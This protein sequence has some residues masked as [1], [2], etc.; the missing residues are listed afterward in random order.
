MRRVVLGLAGAVVAVG[1]ALGALVARTPPG[2]IETEL[3]EALRN[4]S[5]LT[6][7]A[8]EPVRFSLFPTPHV[9]L[10]DVTVSDASG[11]PVMT[12]RAVIA[13]PRIKSL[14]AGAVEIDE[15]TLKTPVLPVDGLDLEGLAAKVVARAANGG[16]LPSLRIVEGA[17]TWSTGRVDAIEAGVVWPRVGRALSLTGV[18]AY[19]GKEVEVRG[20][21]DDPAAAV[22]G[23]RSDLKVKLVGG[24]ARLAFEG[25]AVEAGDGQRRFD[26]TIGFRAGSLKE[27]SRWFGGATPALGAP[28]A[29]VTLS[30]QATIDRTGVSVESAELAVDGAN[31]IGATR[32]ALKDGRPDVEATLAARDLDLTHYLDGFSP[33]LADSGGWSAE[34][35]DVRPFR[36]LDLDLRLSARNVTV[37]PM[38]FGPTAATV[39]V[40][41]GAL[42]VSIGE[43]TAYGGVL[44]GRV[45]VEPDGR[46]AKVR[47]QVQGTDIDVAGALKDVTGAAP[48][49]GALS[50][51][52]TLEG[53]G[54][55]MVEIVRA[56]EGRG[57]A[58]LAGGTIGGFQAKA[59]A[60]L[61]A[62]TRLEIRSADG[63]MTMTRGVAHT[64]DLV[65]G[66]P[67]ATLRLAG[68]ADVASGK[69]SLAGTLAALSGDS[70][71]ARV[72]VDGPFL[73]PKL[74]LGGRR[75]PEHR[76]D[77]AP[78]GPEKASATP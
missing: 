42:D 73:A 50:A 26:G 13:T 16:R 47:L 70:L 46:T 12:A 21:I 55:T 65:L 57:A 40:A 77:V 23:R 25:A 51:D 64:D 63:T 76:S 2:A 31:F 14:L 28:L 27:L 17:V 44:G 6:V 34:S 30:G 56:L 33:A 29:D 15:V 4:G 66:G 36:A 68:E 69:M 3:L 7:A 5:G 54:A 78:T 10:D 53:S 1:V 20:R 32:F 39:S 49:S 18:G 9:R 72:R 19:N 22:Q 41:N 74:R 59:L 71:T 37:G 52:A 60:L 58:R 38:R 62:G 61:G 67:N 45:Q 48:L 43:A 11:A 35:L 24:G 8:R 75:E